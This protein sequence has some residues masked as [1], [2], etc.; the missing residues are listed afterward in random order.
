MKEVGLRELKNRLSEYVNRVKSGDALLVTDRGQP[1]AE[2]RP[3]SDKI[4]GRRPQLSL[5]DLVRAG[6]LIAGKPNDPKVYPKMQR[7]GRRSSVELL[8]EERGER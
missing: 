6:L 7:I 3:I 4:H 2:L 8:D 1:V 5:D